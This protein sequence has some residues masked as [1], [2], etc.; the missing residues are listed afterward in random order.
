MNLV[1]FS[2]QELKCQHCGKH[3]INLE[4]ME[5]IDK[6]RAVCGFP[7]MVTSAYRCEEHPIEARKAKPGAHTTGHAID[8]HCYGDKALRIIEEAQKMGFKRIGIA[9]KGELTKRFIHLDDADELGF[10]S[11]A[12][13][14]Y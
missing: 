13:W 7:F 6:L 1:Y 10:P 3:G 2:D 12:L 8:I 5:K 11:P 4:F 14:T 9:Q